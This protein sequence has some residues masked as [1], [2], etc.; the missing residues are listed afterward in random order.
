M[1]I[2]PRL[3]TVGLRDKRLCCCISMFTELRSLTGWRTGFRVGNLTEMLAWA[4]VSSRASCQHPDPSSFLSKL[5]EAHQHFTIALYYV[6]LGVTFSDEW[7]S[8]LCNWHKRNKWD[9]FS[10]VI[11]IWDYSIFLYKSWQFL[12]GSHG[13]YHHHNRNAHWMVSLPP[14]PRGMLTS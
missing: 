5:P 1:S 7:E 3:R 12:S 14:P 11:L 4:R 8:D 9:V 2:V 10:P 6:W 13:K